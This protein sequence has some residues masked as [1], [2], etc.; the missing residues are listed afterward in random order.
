MK[1]SLVSD[2]IMCVLFCRLLFQVKFTCSAIIRHHEEM[3]TLFKLSQQCKHCADWLWTKERILCTKCHL[4]NKHTTHT[5]LTQ[6][7]WVWQHTNTN[8]CT[9]TN[10]L[11]VQTIIRQTLHHSHNKCKIMCTH[12]HTCTVI[13]PFLHCHI[14][15]FILLK[16]YLCVINAMLT[17]QIVSKIAS[18]TVLW[19]RGE[20]NNHYQQQL[21]S[22]IKFGFNSQAAITFWYYLCV[23]A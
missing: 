15:N 11:T 4:P 1:V 14:S 10:S 18:V 16:N 20:T 5:S 2:Y 21:V 22:R 13:W 17:L 3:V 12:S 6:K 7:T 19:V 9:L 8:P 23:C